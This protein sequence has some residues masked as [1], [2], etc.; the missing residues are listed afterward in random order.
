M[1]KTICLILITVSIL[2]AVGIY[3]WNIARGQAY[4]AKEYQKAERTQQSCLE[5]CNIEYSF[6]PKLP[7]IRADIA[8]DYEFCKA[9]CGEKY[10]IPIFP[11][12]SDL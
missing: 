10:G 2:C 11:E 8:D 1:I 12:F 3:S 5:K 7:L 4:F 9:S 6:D